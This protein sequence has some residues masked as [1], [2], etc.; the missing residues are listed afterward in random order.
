MKSDRNAR[1]KKR[2]IGALLLSFLLFVSSVWVVFDELFEPLDESVQTYTVPH[3][4]GK[5]AADLRTESWLEV[6]T[7]YRYDADTPAG[8]VLSQTPSGG[9]IRKISADRPTCKIKLIVSLGEETV[10]LP[11]VVGADV[12]VAESTLRAAGFAVKCEI[13]T[14]AYSEGEVFDMKPKGGTVLPVGETVTLYASAGTPA[15]TV[16][17]PDLRGLSRGEALMR[18]WLSQLSVLEVVEEDSDEEAGIV[19]R[20]N[21][22]PGTIV[23]AGTKL[24]IT[25]SREWE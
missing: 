2:L 10:A 4:E 15:V 24:T 22:Q 18:I 13:S 12:R 7:E 9:S 16:E 3:F 1:N 21:Y 14:G 11:N 23:M 17:V 5:S 20:Q 6:E 19:I 8:V 25:V